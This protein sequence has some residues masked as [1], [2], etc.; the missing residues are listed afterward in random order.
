MKYHASKLKKIEPAP[1]PAGIGMV[2]SQVMPFNNLPL[3]EQLHL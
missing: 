3:H 1:V 2:S